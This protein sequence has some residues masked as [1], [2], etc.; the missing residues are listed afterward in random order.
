[1]IVE[2]TDATFRATCRVPGGADGPERLEHAASGGSAK[3]VRDTAASEHL[4]SSVEDDALAG[5]DR[6]L[7]RRELDPEAMTIDGLDDRGVLLASVPHT[8]IRLEGPLGRG[9]S[10]DPRHAVGEE[11]PPLQKLA[12]THDE[13]VRASV[14][15]QD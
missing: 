5:R 14:H 15:L 4:V 9:R 8:H 7:R 13:T 10:R 2:G 11:A 6:A 12:G 3:G 1:M